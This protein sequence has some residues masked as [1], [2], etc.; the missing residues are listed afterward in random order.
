MNEELKKGL[1]AFGAKDYV[2]AFR[3]LLPFAEAGG[4]RSPSRC[5]FNV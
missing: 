3:V 4:H 5:R 2:N 1:E